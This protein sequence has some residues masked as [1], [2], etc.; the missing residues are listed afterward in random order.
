[1]RIILLL[2]DDR[3]HSDDV[4]QVLM[5]IDARVSVYQVANITRALKIIENR[6][7]MLIV[8]AQPRNPQ[9][10]LENVTEI[11]KR[12]IKTFLLVEVSSK[13]SILSLQVLRKDASDFVKTSVAPLGVGKAVLD[14]AF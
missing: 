13:H 5:Q 12:L 11:R 14:S 9:K 7:F 10:N 6:S 8:V 1:M 4:A 2:S 3:R